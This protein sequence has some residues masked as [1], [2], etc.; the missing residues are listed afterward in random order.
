MCVSRTCPSLCI[1]NTLCLHTCGFYDAMLDSLFCGPDN[2]MEVKV[3]LAHRKKTLFTS[4]FYEPWLDILP[5][6]LAKIMEVQ[7]QP[8]CAQ[9]PWL[10]SLLYDLDNNMESPC[11]TMFY[12]VCTFTYKVPFVLTCWTTDL[13]CCLSSKQT[14]KNIQS[15]KDNPFNL[16]WSYSLFYITI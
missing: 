13:L 8:T 7:V 11:T 10:G 2:H 16:I 14:R 5:W 3:W 4:G 9:E 15:F 6:G 1:V 12:T